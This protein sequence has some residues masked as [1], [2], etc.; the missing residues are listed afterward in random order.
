ME[1]GF[2]QLFRFYNNSIINLKKLFLFISNKLKLYIPKLWNTLYNNKGASI[3]TIVLILSIWSGD[4]ITY[5]FWGA[6][7]YLLT[8]ITK[9]FEYNKRKNELDSIDPL[10][11]NKLDK[12]LDEY[13]AAC[14]TRD[15]AFYRPTLNAGYINE[16]EINA[17]LKEL[18]DSVV[19]S[20][21]P[22]MRTK[23][24]LY[25]GK[26]TLNSLIARKCYIQVSLLAANNNKNIHMRVP[27]INSK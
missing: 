4:Y 16:K 24:E 6:I 20:M 25:Y 12:E 15:V 26:E 8:F 19:I 5:P 17:Q 13:I 21:G 22:N 9:K 27:N 10:I 7:L 18:L 11:F 23:L 2:L 3:L 14:Y 1:K